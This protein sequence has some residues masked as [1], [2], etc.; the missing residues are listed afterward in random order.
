MKTIILDVMDEK[1]PIPVVKAARALQEMQEPGILE[2]RVSSENAATNLFHLA[3]GHKLP[4]QLEKRE[5]GAYAVRM[6]VAQP[7]GEVVA[8]AEPIACA[9]TESC[10]PG[11]V[12]AVSSDC[13]GGGDPELGHILMKSFLFA[14]SQLP[15][16]P[17]TILFYN[18]GAKLTAEGSPV[19]EDLHKM[20]QQGVQMLTCGTCLNFYHL[21]EKLAVG[22]VTNMYTITETLAG[23]ER[24]I[25]P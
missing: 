4:V 18:A 20:E 7:L 6:E 14:L 1:C 19:L 10:D 8:A 23:A 3:R 15:R 21:T 11:L 24:V 13:M 25:R 17:K 9:C 16:L 22:S 5:E 2:V 12:A